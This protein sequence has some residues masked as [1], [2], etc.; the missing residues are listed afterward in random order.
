MLSA[1]WE[2]IDTALVS[3][4]EGNGGLGTAVG[5]GLLAVTGLSVGLLS[6]VFYERWMGARTPAIPAGA[7]VRTDR[8]R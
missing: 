1:A 8:A 2:P 4:H 6:L 7:P 3:V 5:Y